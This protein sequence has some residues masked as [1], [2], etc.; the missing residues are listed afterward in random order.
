MSKMLSKSQFCG[1]RVRLSTQTFP[2]ADSKG[3][4][5]ENDAILDGVHAADLALAR[6]GCSGVLR[7]FVRM[8]S[9]PPSAPKLEALRAYA[10]LRRALL[11]RGWLIPATSL[12][13]VG[14]TLCQIARFDEMIVSIPPSGSEFM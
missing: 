1:G 3:F 9:M 2:T 11:P 5:H 4:S 8:P 12:S 7:L 6:T 13:A 10:E 14:F